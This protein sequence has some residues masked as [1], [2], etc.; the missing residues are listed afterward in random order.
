MRTYGGAGLFAGLPE[1]VDQVLGVSKFTS[2]SAL[3]ELNRRG[4]DARAS[5]LSR[6][7]F[8]LL[9]RNWALGL[10]QPRGRSLEN[11]RWHRPQCYV[12]GD[13][14]SREVSFERALIGALVAANRTDWSNQVPL[15]SGF[16]GHRAFRRRAV[17]LV[18]R[19]TDDCFEFVELKIDS[20]T[21][22]FAAVE[23]LVYGLLW[24][25]SRRD[26]ALLGYG[27]NPILDAKTLR[28]SILAPRPYY[29]DSPVK[30]LGAT[31]NKGLQALA[32]PFGV[33]MDFRFTAFPAAFYWSS[34]PDDPRKARSLDLID[35]LDGR[36]D[37]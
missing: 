9:D 11:F 22:I 33:S 14:P 3:R 19:H 35:L 30:P 21:P 2:K 18:R 6:A 20:D 1:T 28:L 13:N 23:I 5:T 4:I 34:Q 17:D 29:S 15:I 26:R 24:L 10:G 36:E 32:I 25:L 27:S 37:L 16:G 7:L 31:I 12:D 8:D